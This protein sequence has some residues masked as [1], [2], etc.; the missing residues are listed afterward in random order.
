VHREIQAQQAL[1][2]NTV[3]LVF[4]CQENQEHGIAY[5]NRD[6]RNA[7]HAH[8]AV[9]DPPPLCA[10]VT[11]GV[12]CRHSVLQRILQVW[13]AGGCLSV[14]RIDLWWEREDSGEEPGYIAKIG[15]GTVVPEPRN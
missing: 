3:R 15:L 13:A 7:C 6:N 1:P 2:G 11:N 8:D 9:Y 12:R 14:Q 5:N 4:E 10:V